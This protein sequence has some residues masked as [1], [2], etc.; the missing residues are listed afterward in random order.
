[1]TLE[2]CLNLTLFQLFDLMERY[3][4]F[5]EWDI[6]VRTR[7]AGSKSEKPIEPWMRNLHSINK[8]KIDSTPKERKTSSKGMMF[9]KGKGWISS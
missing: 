6:D 4:A 2:D 3:T 1:M 7:M 9:Y 5:V 8:K